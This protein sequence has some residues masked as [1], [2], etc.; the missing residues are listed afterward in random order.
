[1]ALSASF[2]PEI[3]NRKKPIR[4]LVLTKKGGEYG[5][6]EVKFKSGLN[7]SAFFL[8]D[9]LNRYLKI[10]THFTSCIDANSIDKEIHDFKPSHVIL[11]AIWVTP[12]KLCEIQM[13]HRQVIFVVRVHSKVTFLAY[14]GSAIEFIRGLVCVP[15]T[16]IGFNSDETAEDF[17]VILNPH[18][19]AWLPNIYKHVEQDKISI[20]NQVLNFLKPK[21]H[22][23]GYYEFN[24]AC[25]GAIRPMKD[26][27]LQAFAAL[28]YCEDQKLKLMFHV[29]TGR[30]EQ[31]GDS[32]LKNLRS[33][34]KGTR[35]E[36]VE[37]DW[38]DHNEFLKLIKDIDLG[39]QV[40]LN[41]SFNVVTADYVFNYKP[42]VVSEEISWVS[43]LC[44]CENDT[45]SIVNA[46]E[47]VIDNK[48]LLKENLQLLK[49]F[50]EHSIKEWSR[51]LQETQISY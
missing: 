23:G 29:N 40:S 7:N 17:K 16:Y 18:K 46:I 20:F 6:G 15:N 31:R 9:G 13:L 26:I 2:N 33:L 34:F 27:L 41:E 44:K 42:I 45:T 47:R 5:N 12:D 3:V 49:H 30:I 51:F 37:H 43:N 22:T 28:K 21:K 38:L 32:V 36:L 14:E 1:M 39:M 19:L 24:V 8:A 11:E 10:I 4:V 25:F 35:H 48:H 50:N